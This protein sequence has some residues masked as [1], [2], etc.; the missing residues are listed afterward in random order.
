M[1]Y[2]WAYSLK[3]LKV[4]ANTWLLSGVEAYG[5]K[6]MNIWTMPDIQGY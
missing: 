4:I 5:L 2:D 6:A 1:K 3:T